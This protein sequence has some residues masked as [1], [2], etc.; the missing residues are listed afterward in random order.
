MFFLSHYK[1]IFHTLQCDK[2]HLKQSYSIRVFKQ[3][4]PILFEY[5]INKITQNKTSHNF[6]NNLSSA[7]CFGFVSHIQAEYTIVV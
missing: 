7:T 5:T 6:I 3:G 1:F 2:F 4:I